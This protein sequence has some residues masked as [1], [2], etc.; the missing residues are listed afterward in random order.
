MADSNPW[1]ETPSYSVYVPTDEQGLRSRLEFLIGK[2]KQKSQ[3]IN[4]HMY[5]ISRCNEEIL[6]RYELG[7]R[8]GRKK[9][10]E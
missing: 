2:V 1:N 4:D 6:T 7:L 8:D 3:E 5:E 9:V 10:N